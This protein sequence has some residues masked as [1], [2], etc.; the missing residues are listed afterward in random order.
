MTETEENNN[1]TTLR[2]EVNQLRGVVDELLQEKETNKRWR[3]WWPWGFIP[4][5]LVLLSFVV[6]GAVGIMYSRN[7]VT[8]NTFQVE[9]AELY[10]V[11]GENDQAL[12]LLD[13]LV[14]SGVSDT[15]TL[16]KIGQIYYDLK[17]FQDAVEVLELASQ[18]TRDDINV[19][20]LL[21]KS[22]SQTEQ[23]FKAITIYEYLLKTQPTV[24]QHYLEMGEQYEI[25]NDYDQTISKYKMVQKLIPEGITGYWKLGNLYRKLNRCDEA[26]E[27]YEKVIEINPQH[28]LSK[29]NI[30]LCY[31]DNK[32]F[33][34]AF[35]EYQKIVI[36]EPDNPQAYFYL[37][38][39]YLSQGHFNQAL[40][41]YQKAVD[42]EPNFA[43]AYLGL[44]KVHL[45][46]GD[47]K[48]ATI[49]FLNVLEFDP[50]HPEANEGLIFCES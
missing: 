48:Q 28:T 49:D 44:G 11:M 20:E 14:K 43:D 25:L 13:R 33:S 39:A 10:Q 21:A 31:M 45:F 16:Q 37:A 47:C 32:D 38:E 1:I 23:P 24:W 5:L 30:G 27:Q 12:E 4:I 34:R 2:N 42:L 15:Q 29:L 3:V 9:L 17:K 50:D 22:Y 19:K 8:D 35:E 26:I 36:L 18:K 40:K 41:P 7:F 46:Q 6:L